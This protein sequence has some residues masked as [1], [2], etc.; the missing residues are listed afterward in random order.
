MSGRN[1]IFPLFL[2][3][4]FIFPGCE[5]IEGV[6]RAGIWFAL[7]AIIVIAALIYLIFSIAYKPK[8]KAFAR[9]KVKVDHSDKQI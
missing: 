2:L 6:F 3:L 9:E 7:F 5:L 8:E 1:I 4:M